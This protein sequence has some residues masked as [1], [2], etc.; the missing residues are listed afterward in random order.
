MKQALLDK[1]QRR[2]VRLA[3]VGLGYVG[4]PLAVEF[5]QAGLTVVGIDVDASKTAA[6]MRGESYIPDIASATVTALVR[7]G[8]LSATTEYAALRDCDAVS[9]CVPTPLNKTRDPDM[10]YVISAATAVTAHAHTGLLIVL[11][12]TTYPGTTEEVL[13]P[14]LQAAGWRIGQDVFLAF[15]PER[16][17][18]GNQHYGV[19][20]TPKVVGG[21]TPDCAEVAQ[22]LYQVAV[23]VIVPVSSLR[24]AEMVKLLENTFRAV[25]IGLVNEMALMCAKLD[26]NVWEV[27]EAAGTKPYGYMKFTPG[28][29]IGGHCIPIDPLYLSWK[30][31]SLNYTARFIELAD[32]INSR[33]PEHVVTLVADALNE[34]GR[35]ING[36]RLLVLGVAY[37][38][39]IDDVRESPGLDV[40]TE[41][42]A[43]KASVSYHDPHVPRLTLNGQVYTSQ[44]LTAEALAEAD[45]VIII[46][47]HS[48]FDW[49]WVRQHARLLVDTRNAVRGAAPRGGARVVRL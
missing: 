34:A 47:D 29:G 48:A 13:L 2:Q 24:A 33:M 23:D 28:P 6:I 44:P 42:L 15:S 27:I 25:N 10:S 11:E 43:R 35:A 32:A 26:V 14:R 39:D 18:P 45:G 20:N 3:V 5:A 19:R 38:R 40:L 36:S 8:R 41:L 49:A 9:I 16:I 4:L 7:A 30:L 21:A 1:I 12:S 31:K 46:T 17:D 22:A 37:K